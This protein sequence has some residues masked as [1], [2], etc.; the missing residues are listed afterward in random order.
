M[1]RLLFVLFAVIVVVSA[2]RQDLL[3]HAVG[4]CLSGRCQPGHT[5]YFENCIP[6]GL[7]PNRGRR[8]LDFSTAVGPCIGGRCP[9]GYA[10]RQQ[11]CLK[12]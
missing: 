8:A 1:N 11:Q 7:V 12:L 2:Q 3:S 4:P 6:Q 10:C 9:P 5:C